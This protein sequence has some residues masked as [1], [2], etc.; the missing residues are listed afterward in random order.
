MRKKE[1]EQKLIQRL[2]QR[3][4]GYY[5]QM[6]KVLMSKEKFFGLTARAAEINTILEEDMGIRIAGNVNE[7][8]REI[9]IKG[10]TVRHIRN[11]KKRK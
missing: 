7:H 2:A 9:Y 3:N 10:E 4:E 5:K 8:G 6:M 11:F 1:Y